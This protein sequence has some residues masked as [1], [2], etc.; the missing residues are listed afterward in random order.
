MSECVTSDTLSIIFGV[1]LGLSEIL[2][3]ISKIKRSRTITV[4][5]TEAMEE[6]PVEHQGATSNINPPQLTEET[7]TETKITTESVA[8]ET[9]SRVDTLVTQTSTKKAH[10]GKRVDIFPSSLTEVV[11]RTTS[12]LYSMTKAPERG[13]MHMRTSG[14]Q[15]IIVIQ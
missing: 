10:L 8:K 9:S 14:R 12:Q 6:A 13:D 15:D 5:T 7:T 4:N 2:S 11:W 3:I 1:L